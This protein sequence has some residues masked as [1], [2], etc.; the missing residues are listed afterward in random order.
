MIQHEDIR[1]RIADLLARKVSLVEFDRSLNRDSWGMFS[2]GSD[3]SAINLLA[4]ANLL[5]S[6]LYEGIIEDAQFRQE[7]ASMLGHVVT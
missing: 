4:S 2:D 5:V 7:L 1:E 6:E 3:Q